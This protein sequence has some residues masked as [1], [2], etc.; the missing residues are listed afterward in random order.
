M[1]LALEQ[2]AQQRTHDVYIY[3]QNKQAREQER[4][5]KLHLLIL[6]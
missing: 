4:E 3:H 5:N 2:E 1:Q 6:S